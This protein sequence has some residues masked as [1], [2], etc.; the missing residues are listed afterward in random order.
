MHDQNSISNLKNIITTE[1]EEQWVEIKVHSY[2]EGGWGVGAVDQRGL[3]MC[4]CL[5]FNLRPILFRSQPAARERLQRFHQWVQFSRK[6]QLLHII[7][8]MMMLILSLNQNKPG[9][10]PNE[11]KFGCVICL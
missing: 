9:L 8:L 2:F 10:S 5:S 6:I 1:V 4:L 3:E 7:F 11:P